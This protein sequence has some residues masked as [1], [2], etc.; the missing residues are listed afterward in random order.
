[1]GGGRYRTHMTPLH[2]MYFVSMPLPFP[3]PWKWRQIQ[4]SKQ[5]SD[6]NS[7]DLSCDKTEDAW[8]T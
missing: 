4:E 1:M 6:P 7:N 5:L 2:L 3:L 8:R